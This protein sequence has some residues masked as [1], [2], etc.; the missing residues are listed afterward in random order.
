[1]TQHLWGRDD[2]LMMILCCHLLASYFVMMSSLYFYKSK[3]YKKYNISAPFYVGHFSV[4]I[5]MAIT[6]R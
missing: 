2:N 5:V 3:F 1:M 4:K 6:K